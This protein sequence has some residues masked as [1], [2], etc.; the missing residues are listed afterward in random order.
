MYTEDRPYSL[1]RHNLHMSS[2]WPISAGIFEH[3]GD[4]VIHNHDFIEIA[5]V[6]KGEGIH[7]SIH[8]DEPISR[9]DVFILRPGAWHSYRQC[10]DMHVFN[11]TFGAEFLEKELSFVAANPLLNYMFWTGPLANERKGIL[12]FRISDRARTGCRAEIDG[13]LELRGRNDPQM[14]I[15]WVGHFMLLLGH[16]VSGLDI[17]HYALETGKPRIHEA[18]QEG[19]HLLEGDMSRDWTLPELAAEL[20]ISPSYLLRLFKESIGLPPLS[21]LARYRAEQAAGLLLRTDLSIAAIGARVGWSNPS[22]FSQRFKSHFGL[23]A[24][25]YRARFGEGDSP[26]DGLK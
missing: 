25:E 12:A 23:T 3:D 10:K 16:L 2:A 4:N 20:F 11:C 19:I 13:L 8:G 22:Y 15:R 7:H 5:I 26:A 24:G 17:E 18:V 14:R 9:N 6:L 21:Y 1:R